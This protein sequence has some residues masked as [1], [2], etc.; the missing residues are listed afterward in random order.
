MLT[1]NQIRELYDHFESIYPLL[2]YETYKE[3][4]L[5]PDPRDGSLASSVHA[6]ASRVLITIWDGHV[7]TPRQFK[8]IYAGFLETTTN[9]Y[10]ENAKI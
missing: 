7:L 8:E 4:L 9:Q 2:R 3:Y 6:H 1:K 5:A 10:I